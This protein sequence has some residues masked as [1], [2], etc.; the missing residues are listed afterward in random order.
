M[1]GLNGDCGEFAVARLVSYIGLELSHRASFVLA[2]AYRLLANG[3]TPNTEP[4]VSV[5][6][7]ID[8]LPSIFVP[9]PLTSV[10]AAARI[11]Q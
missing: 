6:R 4:E 2:I 3:K 5:I 9:F 7:L 1:R 10:Q 8:L 11:H